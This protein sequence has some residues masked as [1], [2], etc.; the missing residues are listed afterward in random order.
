MVNIGSQKELLIYYDGGDLLSI[1]TDSAMT[2][3]LFRKAN[4]YGHQGE[5]LI[6]GDIL[7]YVVPSILVVDDNVKKFIKDMQFAIV[8]YYSGMG[9]SMIYNIDLY[10]Q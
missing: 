3:K 6:E 7:D 9:Y 10:D 5:S 4:N 8:G 1:T 2:G